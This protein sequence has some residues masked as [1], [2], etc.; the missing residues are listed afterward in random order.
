VNQRTPFLHTFDFNQF[1]IYLQYI[2]IYRQNF[3]DGLALG[4]AEFQEDPNSKSLDRYDTRLFK[5]FTNRN[6]TI[7]DDKLQ[8]TAIT[9]N[10]IIYC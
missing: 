6:E 2:I 10:N 9:K 1:I 5:E 4:T 8:I 3:C 7:R